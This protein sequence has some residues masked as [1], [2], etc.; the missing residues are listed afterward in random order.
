VRQGVMFNI[1]YYALAYARAS[2]RKR[3]S[4]G[5]DQLRQI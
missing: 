4:N 1:A 5:E 3:N 2:A